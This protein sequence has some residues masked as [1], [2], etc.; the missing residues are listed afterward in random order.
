[1]HMASLTS[2]TLFP[3]L[4]GFRVLA[5]TPFPFPGG[6]LNGSHILMVHAAGRDGRIKVW[7]VL[8]GTGQDAAAPPATRRMSGRKRPVSIN[9]GTGGQLQGEASGSACD[10]GRSGRV[11][12]QRRTLYSA[13][14]HQV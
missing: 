8:K 9:G 4:G 13:K 1:M 6:V 12:V 14:A 3:F 11:E 10:G 7:D 5:D 2:D